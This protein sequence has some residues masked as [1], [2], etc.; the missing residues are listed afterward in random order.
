MKIKIGVLKEQNG[1]QRVALTPIGVE[2]LLK[3]YDVEL[4]VENDIGNSCWLSSSDYVGAKLVNRMIIYRASDILLK[5]NPPTVS[6]INEYRNE[7]TL[8]TQL[9]PKVNPEL[10]PLLSDKKINC[11]AMERIPRV[12]KAQ[13]MD[14]LYSQATVIGYKAVLMAANLYQGFF[15]RLST[16]AG[17]F[18]PVKVLVVGAGGVAGLKAVATAKRLGAQV[19][20][21][22]IRSEIEE[23]IK[24]LGAE[25]VDAGIIAETNEGIAR[26]LTETEREQQSLILER[27]LSFC[28]IV[29]TVAGVKGG[30]RA[31]K[32]ITK[33]MFE[34]LKPGSVVIDVLTGLGGNCELTKNGIQVING[35]TL[36]GMDN[37]PSELARAASEMYSKNIV[38]FLKLI[39]VDSNLDLDLNN[40]ILSDT[41]VTYRGD[42][43]I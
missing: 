20:A 41:L 29:I 4:L 9:Y 31:P 33:T 2:K 36:V 16:A 15:P 1:E 8:I 3:N 34:K 7:L 13:G 24:S 10:L 38:N 21:Y 14:V 27:Y 17:S 12:T 11:F 40:D 23:Q 35:V 32:I 26:T 42:I 19:F 43:R 25:F 30:Q 18:S 39:L 37:L 28:E 5:V 6:E 22:D